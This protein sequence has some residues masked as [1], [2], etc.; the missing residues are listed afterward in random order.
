MS[1]QKRG[2]Y[3]VHEATNQRVSRLRFFRYAQAK[4]TFRLQLSFST[5]GKSETWP[6]QFRPRTAPTLYFT[7]NSRH[8]WRPDRCGCTVSHCRTLSSHPDVWTKFSGQTRIQRFSGT[9]VRNAFLNCIFSMENPVDRVIWHVQLCERSGNIDV[10]SIRAR[11]KS[12]HQCD[13]VK[14]FRVSEG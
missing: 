9:A 8:S 5:R 6:S 2:W 12:S 3:A 1:H 7:R 10:C 4:W 14:H 11:N 13:V